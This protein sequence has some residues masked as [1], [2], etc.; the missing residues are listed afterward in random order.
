VDNIFASR[1]T[2][3]FYKV[4][5]AHSETES[6]TQN[7]A[8][9]DNTGQ[10][11]YKSKV[12]PIDTRKLELSGVKVSENEITLNPETKLEPKCYQIPSGLR[13]MRKKTQKSMISELKNCSGGSAEGRVSLQDIKMARTNMHLDEG[14]SIQRNRIDMYEN[15]A[16]KK[17]QSKSPDRTAASDS[18][19]ENYNPEDSIQELYKPIHCLNMD[20]NSK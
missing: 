3:N 20:R 11:F 4:P 18:L 5:S 2:A 10:S 9:L 7:L 8:Q 17:I 6:D 14:S 12:D 19:R 16:I 13:L 1:T 15:N